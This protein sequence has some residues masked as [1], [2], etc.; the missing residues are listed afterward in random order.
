MAKK[1][2]VIALPHPLPCKFD[3]KALEVSNELIPPSIKEIAECLRNFLGQLQD[4][5]DLEVPGEPRTKL[6]LDADYYRGY[7]IVEFDSS[8]SCG[9]VE[10]KKFLSYLFDRGQAGIFENRFESNEIPLKMECIIREEAERARS[11]LGGTVLTEEVSVSLG[12][13]QI[14]MA[15]GK[16]KRP[17]SKPPVIDPGQR[18]IIGSISGFCRSERLVYFIKNDEKRRSEYSYD[19]AHLHETVSR[20]ALN[21]FNHVEI[22]VQEFSVGNGKIAIT[23]VS[24]KEIEKDPSSLF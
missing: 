13:N 20:I 10:I 8:A 11:A 12:E 3:G 24:V 14:F 7:V 6:A 19:P 18:I 4:T 16:I 17:P 1:E 23:I 22:V 21:V 15:S 9:E 2:I 5:S